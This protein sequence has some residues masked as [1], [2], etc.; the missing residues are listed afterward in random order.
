MGNSYIEALKQYNKDKNHWTVPRKGT[1][2]HAEVLR[3]MATHKSKKAL[4]E[5]EKVP[6]NLRRDG[7]RV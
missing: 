6:V 1:P 3:L 2:G 4:A 5:T 7:D